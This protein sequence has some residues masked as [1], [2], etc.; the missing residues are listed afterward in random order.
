MSKTAFVTDSVASIPAEYVQRYN[1][2][3]VPNIVIWLGKEYR[4]GVDITPSELF[5][6]LKT[7]KELPTTAA[8]GPE[9]YKEVFAS[10]LADG[11]DILGI[12]QSSTMTRT[13]SSA[14]K[15]KEMLG[16]DNIIVLDSKTMGMAVGWP[17]I[18]AARAAENGASLS[19]CEALAREGL[20]NTGAI[21]TV[22]SLEH[23]RRSGRIGW[24]QKYMGSLLNVK[25]IMEAV[26]GQIVPIGQVRTRSKALA[27][28]TEM[29]VARV[30]CRSPLHLAIGHNDALDDA[31]TL[32]AMI[33]ERLKIE[34]FIIGEI[35]SIGAVL[36][37][38]GALGISFMAGVPEP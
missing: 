4:D 2:H 17:L 19:E 18:L 7:N 1:I 11:F 23:L 13:Y 22:D 15:A 3:V 26:D 5:A 12:L 10:L 14:Q 6:R 24:A 34:E 21:A 20:S 28:L 8:V 31:R 32:M 16:A 38:P 9:T 29:T 30:N 25:P 37:G 33:Q 36:F 35:S 27:E